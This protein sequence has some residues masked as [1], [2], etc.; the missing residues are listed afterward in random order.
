M[1]LIDEMVLPF[2]GPGVIIDG[3]I[4]RSIVGEA[5]IQVNDILR[6]DIK[7]LFDRINFIGTQVTT[8]E[9]DNRAFG[10][11]QFEEEFLLVRSGAD[12]SPM[13]TSA[14]CSP[15]WRP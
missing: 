7:G 8:F 10:G 3:C 9:C 5:A 2:F 15:E 4:D 11:A 6:R 1:A 14:G 12:H 13:T